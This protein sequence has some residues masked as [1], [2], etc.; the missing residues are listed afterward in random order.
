MAENLDWL[1]EGICKDE[2]PDLFFPI[3]ND[4]PALLQTAQ[5]KAVCRRCPVKDECLQWALET[6]QDDGVWGAL[7][8]DERRRLRTRNMSL[9]IGNTAIR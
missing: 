4:G 5:A 8:K 2:D 3:G 7:S 1:T 9:N 6:G